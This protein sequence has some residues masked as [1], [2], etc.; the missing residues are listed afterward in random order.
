MKAWPIC[1]LET[2]CY[3]RIP[4]NSRSQQHAKVV[5]DTADV[6]VGRSARAVSDTVGALTGAVV[7][8]VSTTTGGA[9]GGRLNPHC[10]SHPT[11]LKT[12]CK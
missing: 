3:N 9:A 5:L 7:G 10:K 11:P 2:A 12:H 4:I 6:A 1:Y 8:V